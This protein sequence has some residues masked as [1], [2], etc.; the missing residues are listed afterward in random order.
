[1]N[2]FSPYM[3]VHFLLG[4]PVKSCPTCYFG[5]LT[6]AYSEFHTADKHGKREGHSLFT[7]ASCCI[8]LQR[9]TR[10]L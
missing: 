6:L 9:Y 8:S 4:S 3:D 1:M 7:T 5:H 2:H 10:Q